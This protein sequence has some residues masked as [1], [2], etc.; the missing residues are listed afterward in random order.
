[1]PPFPLV[2][3]DYLGHWES[4]IVYLIIGFAFGAVLEMSG[5][6]NAQ[7][8]ANQFYFKDLTVL[9]VMF[10]GIIV[11]M[12]L[13]FIAT[14][15]G[16]LDYNLIW[17]NPTYLWPGIVG[18]VLMGVGF[19]IG[20]FCPGTSLVAAATLKVDGI[21]F[22]MGVVF[23]IFL[24]GESVGYYEDFWNSSYEGRFTLMELLDLN[25]GIIVLGVVIMALVAFFAGEQAE[26]YFG[27]QPDSMRPQWRYYAAGGILVLAFATVIIGQ[28]TNADRWEGIADEKTEVLE[29]RE[30]QIH[31]A[32]LLATMQDKRLLTYVI[33]VR[34]ESDYNLFHIWDSHNI[35]IND[36]ADQIEIF[37]EQPAN[38]VFV[39]ISNDETAATE[40]WKYLVAESIPNMYILEGGINNWIAVFGDEEFLA[41]HPPIE[42][43]VDDTLAYTF[44]AALGA[45][46]PISFPDAHLTDFE[47]TA[48]IVLVGKRGATGGGCG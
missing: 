27:K 15:L 30:V 39:V 24:F 19:I 12:T 18:G 23:G 43:H 7:K 22:V 1:M 14:G 44:T 2:L 6:A 42:D 48:K 37:Q 45:R 17:V 32:E 46:Y 36:F 33:D 28:P 38:T 20:G 10:T 40:A 5:F 8:L 34:S 25:T 29:N 31:P 16:L 3:T 47:Y 21:F 4:Y 13:I 11:A 35:R 41:S 26:R 9:K